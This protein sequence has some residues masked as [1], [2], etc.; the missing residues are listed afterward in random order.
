MS[1]SSGIASIAQRGAVLLPVSFAGLGGVIFA[2]PIFIDCAACGRPVEE[3]A[4]GK[5]PLLGERHGS[6]AGLFV[7]VGLLRLRAA[8][9]LRATLCL[10]R[11]VPARVDDAAKTLRQG[12]IVL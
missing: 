2:G 4:V 7:A 11:C 3:D 5:K 1:S 10:T 12:D 9:V 8:W 6:H